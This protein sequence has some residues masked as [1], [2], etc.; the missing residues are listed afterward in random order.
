MCMPLNV[1]DR[2]VYLLVYYKISCLHDVLWRWLVREVSIKIVRVPHL[3]ESKST[4]V[5]SIVCISKIRR[6]SLEVATGRRHC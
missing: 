4:W 1:F 3:D 2:G 5:E 6:V